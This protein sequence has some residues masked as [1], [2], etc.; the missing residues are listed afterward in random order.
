MYSHYN[1]QNLTLAQEHLETVKFMLKTGVQ[2]A[3]ANICLC[4]KLQ[5][6]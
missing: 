4:V 3:D 5:Q 2:N 1:Q 6:I